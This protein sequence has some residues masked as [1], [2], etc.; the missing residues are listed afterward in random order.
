MRKATEQSDV[1]GNMMPVSAARFLAALMIEGVRIR[2]L[3]TCHNF[4]LCNQ[5][6]DGNSIRLNNRSSFANRDQRNDV[7]QTFVINLS[8]LH[9]T[10]ILL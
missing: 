7:H 10:C 9:K 6:R 3:I 8:R 5:S 4:F 1:M 2:N